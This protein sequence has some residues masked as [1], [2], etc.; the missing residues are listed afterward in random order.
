MSRR[1]RKEKARN[2]KG[3]EAARMESF[4]DKRIGMDIKVREV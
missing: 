2:R 3:N 1:D 4:Q